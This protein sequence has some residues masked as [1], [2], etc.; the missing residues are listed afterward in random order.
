MDCYKVLLI[1]SL[2]LLNFIAI[3]NS[4][5]YKIVPIFA[6]STAATV[7]PPYADTATGTLTLNKA[8]PDSVWNSANALISITTS[9]GIGGA[10]RQTQFAQ[11]SNGSCDT[12]VNVTM[13]RN[14]SGNGQN[15]YTCC[16]TIS[17]TTTVDYIIYGM[18]ASGSAGNALVGKQSANFTT[19][20]WVKFAIVFD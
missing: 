20:C 3:N 14:T 18:F 8:I 1:N 13:V 17:S 6:E 5:T 11:C 15:L 2:N 4:I 9:A 10:S 19:K 12:T 7:S 16:H